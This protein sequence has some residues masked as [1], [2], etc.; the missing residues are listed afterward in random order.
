MR[1][2]KAIQISDLHAEKIVDDVDRW[3]CHADHILSG[4]EWVDFMYH[5]DTLTLAHF[6]IDTDELRP[7]D[8]TDP[9]VPGKRP[10]RL[11]HAPNHRHLKG[12]DAIL[13]AVQTLKEEGH[14]IDLAI[15]EKQPNEEV[16]KEIARADVV[17]DQ[18]VMGWY[19]MFALEAM[20]LGKPIVCY[21]R[22]DLSDFYQ[23]AGLIDE[24]ELP[25]L[26]ADVLR[27][28]TLIE[29]IAEG[30]YDLEKI[31]KRGRAFVE[32]HHSLQAVGATFDRINR[33]LGV[34]PD[35]RL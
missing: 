2:G 18:I 7:V 25:F 15:V 1:W 8:G 26:S 12:T 34:S 27:V 23:K 13:E 24:D 14:Q 22:P 3:T 31:G 19:A 17:L 9:Y 35:S 4:V 6:S 21:I 11:L 33:D 10:L 28:K 20:A 5:W 16:L 32:K 30:Q 29:E